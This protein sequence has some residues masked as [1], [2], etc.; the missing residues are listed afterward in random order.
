MSTRAPPGPKPFRVREETRSPDG[1]TKRVAQVPTQPGEIR[2]TDA[3]A[4]DPLARKGR[5]RDP[6]AP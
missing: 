4:R 5:V 6:V 3:A 1:G 2:G